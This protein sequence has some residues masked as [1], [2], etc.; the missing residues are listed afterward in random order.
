LTNSELGKSVYDQAHQTELAAMRK[1]IQRRKDSKVTAK[2]TEDRQLRFWDQWLPEGLAH[3]LVLMDVAS[4]ALTAPGFDRLFTTTGQAAPEARFEL[5]P[6]G[7]LIA[8]TIN[9]TPPPYNGFLNND[10]YLVATDGSGALKNLT[11]DNPGADGD[12]VFA[13][14]N[15]SFVYRRTQTS[16]NT[17]EFAR[18]WRHDLATGTNTPLTEP[19]D[20]AIGSAAF[21]PDRQSL[22]VTAEEK[23]MLPIFKL[24]ADGSGFASG[25]FAEW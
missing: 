24:A 5:S 10:I 22:W 14:D 17:A 13:P 9:S 3:R 7:Q 6:D 23:G 12:A 18:L 11:S 8:V 21:S 2:A 20:Y 19:L 16:Y 1:E 4:R 25:F 15:R